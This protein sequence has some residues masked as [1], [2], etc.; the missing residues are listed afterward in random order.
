MN[1][2]DRANRSGAPPRGILLA[3]DLGARS[4][5]AFDRAVQLARAWDARLVELAISN[6][7]ANAL[8]FSP[9]GSRIA[10]QL[11]PQRVVVQ[12]SGPGVPDALMHKLGERF[13]TTPRPNG[14]RSG[15]GLGLSIVYR[16]MQL[17]GGQL[18]FANT[19]PGL[20][21][22]LDFSPST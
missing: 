17:H 13:F 6:L 8:D 14:E 16:I 18:H 19:A 20:R 3:S 22:V 21:V 12:D 10:V 9:P 1:G 4:D 7:L 11:A 5:R 15:T 2:A